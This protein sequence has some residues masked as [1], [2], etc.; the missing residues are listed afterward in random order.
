MFHMISNI[1]TPVQLQQ[2]IDN[3]DSSKRV[4][5]KCITYTLGW[6]NLVDDYIQK[7]TDKPIRLASGFYSFQQLSER[8]N[9]LGI[10]LVVNETNGIVFLTSPVELKISKGLK[11]ILGLGNKRRLN[12]NQTYE[13]EMSL[14]FAIHKSL[15]VHLKE[16]NTSKNYFNGAPSNVLAIVPVL[17]REFGDVVTTRFE[18]PEYKCLSNG[19]VSE[20]TLEIRDSDNNVI[21]NNGLPIIIVLEII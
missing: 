11:T 14:D 1:N 4:G 12:A 6:Y 21:N 20:L 18:H 13:G 8:F 3:R 19:T 10:H 5:L 16:L 7:G 17:N 9:E 15:F 2:Y